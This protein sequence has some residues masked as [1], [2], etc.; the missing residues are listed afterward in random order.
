VL[1]AGSARDAPRVRAQIVQVFS[2][3]GIENRRPCKRLQY[4]TGR[5]ARTALLE[6]GVVLR[7]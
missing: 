2:L 5:I 6:A 3:G 1:R 4:F 7:G